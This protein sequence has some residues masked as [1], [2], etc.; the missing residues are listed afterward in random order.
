M[1]N[2]LHTLYALHTSLGLWIQDLAQVTKTYGHSLMSASA[3]LDTIEHGLVFWF[4]HKVVCDSDC[5]PKALRDIQ[6]FSPPC[7]CN[8]L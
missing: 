7:L 6:A 8:F 4:I 1:L 5:P 3:L 2:M